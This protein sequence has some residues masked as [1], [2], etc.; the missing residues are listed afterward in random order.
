MSVDLNTTI[1]ALQ[2]EQGLKFVGVKFHKE[3]GDFDLAGAIDETEDETG[4]WGGKTYHY[5]T[6]EECS[7]GDF[8]VVEA[9]GHLQVVKV[10]ATDVDINLADAASQKAAFPKRSG[11]AFFAHQN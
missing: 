2:I 3:C 7:E 4:Y 5:K 10:V 8:L 11:I 6:T 9:R 1:L